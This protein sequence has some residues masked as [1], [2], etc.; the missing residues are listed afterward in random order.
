ME[1]EREHIKGVIVLGLTHE[2]CDY[3]RVNAWRERSEDI[4]AVIILG[5][6]YGVSEGTYQRCCY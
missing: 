6:T 1:G 3:M 4:K 5:L 2:R